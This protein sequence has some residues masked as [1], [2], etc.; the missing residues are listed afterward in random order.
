MALAKDFTSAETLSVLRDKFSPSLRVDDERLAPIVTVF[1][2]LKNKLTEDGYRQAVGLLLQYNA[3]K[4]TE[5]L[6]DNILVENR[7]LHILR[8]YDS[9]RFELL[10][11]L[12]DMENNDDHILNAIQHNRIIKESINNEGVRKDDMQTGN[13]LLCSSSNTYDVAVHVSE[14]DTKECPS[15]EFGLSRQLYQKVP[16]SL[17]HSNVADSSASE[18]EMRDV[19][20]SDE[21]KKE[22]LIVEHFDEPTETLGVN[23]RSDKSSTNATKMVSAKRG[24]SKRK[25]LSRD[26][27]GDESAEEIS[28]GETGVDESGSIGES[29]IM[30]RESEMGGRSRKRTRRLGAREDDMMLKKV[31]SHCIVIGVKEHAMTTDSSD[32]NTQSET[33]T[34]GSEP[35]TSQEDDE[36]GVLVIDE[37]KP[38]SSL[39]SKKKKRHRSGKPAANLVKV[40]ALCRG[41]SMLQKC[42]MRNKT[43]ERMEEDRPQAVL[44]RG[45]RIARSQNN[46]TN[47][48]CS[49]SEVSDEDVLN[50]YPDVHPRS[51]DSS[52]DK[53][54]R[55]KSDDERT[56]LDIL[57]L[58]DSQN[59]RSE[60]HASPG[61]NQQ[62][63]QLTRYHPMHSCPDRSTSI[64]PF[65]SYLGLQPCGLEGNILFPIQD[66]TYRLLKE[67]NSEMRSAY[68]SVKSRQGSSLVAPRKQSKSTH[69][70]YNPNFPFS[71]TAFS[72]MSSIAEAT[73]FE[74]SDYLHSQESSQ[75]EILE[76]S[77]WETTASSQDSRCLERERVYGLGTFAQDDTDDISFFNRLLRS[78]SPPSFGGNSDLLGKKKRHRHKPKR[79][80]KP[81]KPRR[82][83]RLRGKHSQ[84]GDG[85]TNDT[86]PNNANKGVT[87]RACTCCS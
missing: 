22:V 86:L 56:V 10:D 7:L 79:E 30:R 33:E 42:E 24:S 78:P 68:N 62:N 19:A 40:S 66:D 28:I 20:P 54:I 5:K 39:K 52:F 51:E 4:N 73:T 11:V 6:Y 23:D 87:G 17:H 46:N 70:K 64:M 58:A 71:T 57:S 31:G 3:S 2:K 35:K 48:S 47:N 84:D 34:M 55:C 75:D 41:A 82:S 59:H 14:D 83:R 43:G 45:I 61:S 27:S 38:S 81:R 63:K 18:E 32:N 15:L 76:N 85:G 69:P 9:L 49:A 21:P 12:H 50:T 72:A 80:R 25:A 60:K 1:N 36:E 44:E 29:V 8:E 37:K 16:T 26:V 65:T 77:G 74:G 67:D 13:H 53:L